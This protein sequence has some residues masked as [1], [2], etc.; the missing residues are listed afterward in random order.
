MHVQST[1]ISD[2][3]SQVGRCVDP[4]E[5]LLLQY[6]ALYKKIPLLGHGKNYL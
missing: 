2:G 5:L 6:N 4:V 3:R 1:T